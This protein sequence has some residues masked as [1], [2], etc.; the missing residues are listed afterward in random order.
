M[1]FFGRSRGTE[2]IEKATALVAFGPKQILG[3]LYGILSILDTKAAGL[4]TVDAFLI[5]ALIAFFASPQEVAQQFG[6]SVPAAVLE[7]QLASMGISAFLCLLV[8]RVTWRCMHFVPDAPTSAAD[9]DLEIRRLSNSID[10][11]TRYYWFASLFALLGFVLT[12]AW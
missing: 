11:R 9:F 7:L 6:L 2:L 10:D 5:A 1:W 3:Q 8:V 4:L 12:L